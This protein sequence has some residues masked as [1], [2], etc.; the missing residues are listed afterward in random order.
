MDVRNF[1]LNTPMIRY[2]YLQ[3]QMGDIPN[4]VQKQD[5]IHDKATTNGY[6]HVEIQKG[7]YG[8]LKGG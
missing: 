4:N 8:I 3:L 2:K 7:M 1:Y 5:S 6:V